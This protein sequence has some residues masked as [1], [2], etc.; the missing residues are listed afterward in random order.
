MASSPLPILL[1]IAVAF[2]QVFGGV[3]CCCL[4]RSLFLD[5]GSSLTNPESNLEHCD[6]QKP[7]QR[8][9]AAKALPKCPRCSSTKPARSSAK[10]GTPALA[11]SSK[12][13]SGMVCKSDGSEHCQ[14]TKYVA[15]AELSNWVKSIPLTS[16]DW[17][18]FNGIATDARPSTSRTLNR[19]TSTRHSNRVSW[20]AY[21][22]I[23]TI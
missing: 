10:N 11:K 15:A 7:T 6:S 3:S 19:E 16:L 13:M 18:F 8:S 1:L 21:A 22:C 5:W 20:Q 14:C 23:W 12:P 2:S 4:S 9:V 17:S